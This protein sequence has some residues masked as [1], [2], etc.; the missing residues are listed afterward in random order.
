MIDLDQTE[1]CIPGGLCLSPLWGMN[2]LA[3]WPDRDHLRGCL[4]WHPNQLSK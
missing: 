1:V 2:L 4:C 3:L